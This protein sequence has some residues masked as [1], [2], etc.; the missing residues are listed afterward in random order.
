MYKARVHL[1]VCPET[2]VCSYHV[3][4]SFRYSTGKQIR[5]RVLVRREGLQV[6]PLYC[7]IRPR[8]ILTPHVIT[9]LV[10]MHL[11][12][13]R[14]GLKASAK[15]LKCKCQFN[16]C[17]LYT[18]LWLVMWIKFEL[19]YCTVEIKNVIY[20]VSYQTNRGVLQHLKSSFFFFF[21]FSKTK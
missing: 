20:L 11:F 10:S 18:M 16:C 9:L 2:R 21:F 5:L 15:L 14:F 8:V 13:N 4:T 17:S 19:H 3:K 12:G 1:E 6:S 7:R